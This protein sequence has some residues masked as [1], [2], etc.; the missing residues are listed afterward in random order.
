MKA[1]GICHI[2]NRTGKRQFKIYIRA[3]I[4]KITYEKNCDKAM[5]DMPDN[6]I[7]QYIPYYTHLYNQRTK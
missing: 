2:G 5:Y 4:V 3:Y 7:K 6:Y 1:E